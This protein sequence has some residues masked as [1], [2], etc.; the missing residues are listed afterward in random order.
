MEGDQPVDQAPQGE[1]EAGKRVYLTDNQQFQVV[2]MLL[3][4]SISGPLPKK[5]L[6]NVAKKIG[7]PCEIVSRL[8]KG[9]T[10]SRA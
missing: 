10:L 3:G 5:T 7:V 2:A 8:C 6:T 9:A 1:K 4:A